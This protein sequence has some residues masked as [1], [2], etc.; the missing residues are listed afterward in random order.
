MAG[1]VLGF[2]TAL[3]VGLLLIAIVNGLLRP[4][5]VVVAVETDS[6][7]GG[8]TGFLLVLVLVAL[9]MIAL[10]LAPLIRV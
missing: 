3:I 10:G 1:F 6:Q 5:P 9:G 2:V 4:T 8:S 7:R